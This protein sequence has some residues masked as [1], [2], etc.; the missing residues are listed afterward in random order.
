[1]SVKKEKFV[2]EKSFGKIEKIVEDL[3]GG[4]LS[5]DDSLKAYEEGI[6]EIKKCVKYLDEAELKVK[7]LI[8]GKEQDLDE[9][10]TKSGLEE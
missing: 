4:E 9:F 8:D 2:F 6:V 3:E 5:L 1:M 10:T 7:A